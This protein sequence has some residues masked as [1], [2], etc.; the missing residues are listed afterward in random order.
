[1]LDIHG[2]EARAVTGDLSG[3]AQLKTMV[4]ADTS[5]QSELRRAPDSESFIALVVARASER[6]LAIERG[7]IEEA[8]AAGARAWTL[9]WIER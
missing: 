8:L 9:R 5:L 3:L 6:G 7:E 2:D 4:L 1:L